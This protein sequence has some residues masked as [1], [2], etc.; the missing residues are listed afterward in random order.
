MPSRELQTLLEMESAGAGS[1]VHGSVDVRLPRSSAAVILAARTVSSGRQMV[2]AAVRARAA[3][4]LSARSP[5]NLA[6]IEVRVG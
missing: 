1:D 5:R 2:C 4:R 3:G 6:A